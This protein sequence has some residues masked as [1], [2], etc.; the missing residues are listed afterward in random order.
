MIQF[1]FLLQDELPLERKT[2]IRSVLRFAEI[3]YLD[4][5]AKSVK[6]NLHFH[7]FSDYKIH[8]QSLALEFIIMEF[9]VYV[10]HLPLNND[11]Y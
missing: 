9:T 3:K 8:L 1:K 10:L 6:P 4:L 5:K 7:L 2:V 11:L